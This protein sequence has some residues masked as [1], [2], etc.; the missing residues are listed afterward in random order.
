MDYDWLPSS[1]FNSGLLLLL[2]HHEGLKC[3]VQQVSLLKKA[4]NKRFPLPLTGKLVSNIFLSICRYQ[5]MVI[6]DWKIISFGVTLLI[7]YKTTLTSQQLNGTGPFVYVMKIQIFTSQILIRQWLIDCMQV[8]VIDHVTGSASVTSQNNKSNQLFIHFN[9]IF[10]SF[11]LF[12]KLWHSGQY[13]QQ[14][15]G[16]R[17]YVHSNGCTTQCNMYS[18]N[19]FA[20]QYIGLPGC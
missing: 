5:E 4:G 11:P 8:N 17:Q 9:V 6:N 16:Y 19:I 20:K 13:L 7:K 1:G 2:L 15:A 18:P 12:V 14:L 3:W 10:R